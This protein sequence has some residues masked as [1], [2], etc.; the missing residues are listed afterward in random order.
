[1]V[2]W[3]FEVPVSNGFRVFL[4]I[5][6]CKLRKINPLFIGNEV[7]HGTCEMEANSCKLGL[8]FGVLQSV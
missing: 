7:T 6:A 8:S 1:M 2:N 4:A 5:Q 3:F